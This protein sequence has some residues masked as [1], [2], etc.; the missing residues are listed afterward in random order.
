MLRAC[1]T[2][3]APALSLLLLTRLLSIAPAAAGG[4][5]GSADVTLNGEVVDMACY[6]AQGGKGEMH[7]P[8]AA[9]CAKMGQPV[10]LLSGDGSIYLLVAD[11]VDVAPYEKA[12][13][14]AGE[15]VVIRGGVAEKDGISTLTVHE[16][17]KK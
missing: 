1:L 11:H 15:Q 2:A 10:G 6:V 3:L 4:P 16:A 14:L 7:R 8:C 13:G 5:A 12:R 9:K 17:R